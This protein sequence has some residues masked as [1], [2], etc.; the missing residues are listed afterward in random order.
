MPEV[1]TPVAPSTEL[2]TV[3]SADAPLDLATFGPAMQA[4]PSDMQRRFVLALVEGAKSA[5]EAATLAGYSV[6]TTGAASRLAND[7]RVQA[8]LLEEAVKAVRVTAVRALSV[9]EEI[10]F[11]KAA[12]ARD[13]LKTAEMILARGGFAEIARHQVDVVHRT[14]AQLRHELL[15]MADELQLPAEARAKLIGGAVI[16]DAE[17]TEVVDPPT[18]IAPERDPRGAPVDPSAGRTAE[19]R[20][21][22]RLRKAR[23]REETPEEREARQLAE[24]ERRSDEAKRKYADAQGRLADDPGATDGPTETH[25]FAGLEDL[26]GPPAANDGPLANEAGG[27]SDFN[28]LD[29]EQE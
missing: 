2:A 28:P 25:S 1:H 12:H 21:R 26:I 18:D 23:D 16:T 9:L 11:D 27:F 7:P 20:A 17:Y 22:D 14:D 6:K 3:P 4:L 5:K 15:A 24:R 19:D 13:R 10:A 8:A 29:D